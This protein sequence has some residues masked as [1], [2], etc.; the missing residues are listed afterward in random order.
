M[1]VFSMLP[2][3]YIT[4]VADLL[5]SLLPQLEPFAQSSSLENA[6]VASR[7]A[8][9][10]CVQKEWA[11][12][13][14][15]LHLTPLEL[16]TCQRIFES[17]CAHAAADLA[18]TAMEFV[19]VWTATFASGALAAFL[20]R[21]C[22]IRVLTDMGAQQLAADL[23]YFHNVLS[24][25]GG[26]SNFIVDDLRRA[27]ETNMSLHLQHVQELREDRDSPAKQALAKINDCIVAM[28]RQTLEVPRRV[29]AASASSI[30]SS[31]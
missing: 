23:N 15:L 27:L 25:V 31:S 8:Q 16:T 4:I 6:F 29:S 30:S 10:L 17:D 26:E 3:D 1:P 12:L 18:P 11:R 22:S 28:R 2:Q 5:L 14:Q 19:D 7:G 9:E 13:G 21:V 24:A 20:H